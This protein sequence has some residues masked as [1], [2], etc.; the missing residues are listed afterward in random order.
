MKNSLFFLFLLAITLG[1]S[2]DQPKYPF[3][4]QVETEDGIRLP[5]V[6]IE[7]TADVP[8]ALPKFSGITGEDG[9]ISFEYTYEAVLKVRATRGT[10]PPSWMGCNFV[11][12]EANKTVTAKVILIPYD[13][14]QPGC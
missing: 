11:K 6:F 3:V 8:N 9:T 14:T 7:A 4:I 5:N 12:L 2:K 13:P 1:C 10:N